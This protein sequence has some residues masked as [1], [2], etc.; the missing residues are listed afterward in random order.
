M[1]DRE[2]SLAQVIIQEWMKKYPP[3]DRDEMFT[4]KLSS[5]EIAEILADFERVEAGDVTREL[6]KAGYQLERAS[7]GSMKWLIK[8]ST[9][10][11]RE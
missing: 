8:K 2:D 9:D 10:N 7:G 11:E 4:L 3:A 6:L 1:E 5:Y